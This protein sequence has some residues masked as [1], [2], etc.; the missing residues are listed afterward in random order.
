MQCV[1]FLLSLNNNQINKFQFGESVVG[2]PAL[3]LDVSGRVSTLG[4]DEF[5][6]LYLTAVLSDDSEAS[7]STAQN[8]SCQKKKITQL[9]AKTT[10]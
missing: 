4:R 9:V 1:I 2:N 5:A 10:Y 3:F 8:P 7:V 6:N